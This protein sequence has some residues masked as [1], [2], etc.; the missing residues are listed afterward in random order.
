M[1]NEVCTECGKDIY[2]KKTTK[3]VKKEPVKIKKRT[4]CVNCG[5]NIGNSESCP[6]C[7]EG[8]GE[9]IRCVNCGNNVTKGLD[10][11]PHCGTW[12]NLGDD[13]DHKIGELDFSFLHDE[14]L[15]RVI[16]GITK[17]TVKAFLVILAILGVSAGALLIFEIS[18]F[19]NAIFGLRKMEKGIFSAFG[20]IPS[21]IGWGIDFINGF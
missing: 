10:K 7:G 20:V 21:A 5:S 4:I 2:G 9:L 18:L 13:S 11:C 17:F 3:S 1:S 12:M 19:F 16:W 8:N 14:S 15:L 6:Y